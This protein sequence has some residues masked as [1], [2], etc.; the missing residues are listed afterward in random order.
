MTHSYRIDLIGKAIPKEKNTQSFQ[1]H[2]WEHGIFPRR[3]Q[4]IGQ[5]TS[6]T[7]LKGY[8]LYQ[9]F[10]TNINAMELEFNNRWKMAKEQ[11]HGD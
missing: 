11:T 1:M 10:F 4:M 2:I 9:V 5:K 3:D 6:L 8:K 7:K